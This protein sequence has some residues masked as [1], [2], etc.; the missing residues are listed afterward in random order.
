MDTALTATEPSRPGPPRSPGP[1]TNPLGAEPPPHPP[2]P[3]QPPPRLHSREAPHLAAAPPAGSGE[4]RRITAAR[5]YAVPTAAGG[6][7]PRHGSARLG[8][9][10]VRRSRRGSRRR[11]HF[12][13]AGGGGKRACAARGALGAVVRRA[14]QEKAAIG[15]SDVSASRRACVCVRCCERAGRVREVGRDSHRGVKTGRAPRP[16]SPT[17]PQGSASSLRV[18]ARGGRMGAQPRSASA[19]TKRSLP[20][21]GAHRGLRSAAPRGDAWTGE[22]SEAQAVGSAQCGLGA[23]RRSHVGEPTCGVGALTRDSVRGCGWG[24]RGASVGGAGRWGSGCPP[25]WWCHGNHGSCRAAAAMGSDGSRSVP[26][27]PSSVS[28]PPH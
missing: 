10:H 12:P 4:A 16:R 26:A 24:G 28:L 25:R 20:C 18:C 22:R 2:P 19:G 15:V 11:C 3:H 21:S 17:I 6:S 7:S 13:A 5:C 14:G 1:Q 9:S 8:P 23:P 27:L